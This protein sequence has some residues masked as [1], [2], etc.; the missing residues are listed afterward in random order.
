MYG[1][2]MLPACALFIAK[3]MSYISENRFQKANKKAVTENILRIIFFCFQ[4]I[5][6]AIE[7]KITLIIAAGSGLALKTGFI[8][9]GNLSMYLEIKD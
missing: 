5:K 4:R 7:N 3:S 9:L 8:K 2:A 1:N 6:P